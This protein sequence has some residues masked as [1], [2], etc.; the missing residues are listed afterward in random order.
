[1]TKLPIAKA[2]PS[3]SIDAGNPS[4]KA[5]SDDIARERRWKAEDALRDIERAEGHK[6]D[7]TLMKDVKSVAREK[8]KNM[9]KIC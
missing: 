5:S 3:N 6:R 9:Q 7:K 8:I 4:V 1:M 2:P